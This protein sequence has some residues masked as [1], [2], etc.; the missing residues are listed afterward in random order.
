MSR[1]LSTNNVVSLTAQESDVVFLI[2]LTISH[3]DLSED[4][5]VVNNNENIT[6][7]GNEYIAFPF[8]IA[9]PSDADT[10]SANVQLRIDNVDRQIVQA[11]RKISSPASVS[12]EVVSSDDWDNV[13][14]SNLNMKLVHVSYD[15]LTVEGELVLDDILNEGFPADSYLPSNSSIV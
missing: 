10:L 13:E 9:L 15:S 3:P 6:S 8:D 5:R 12:I 14:L 4:I 2:L 11:V 1:T 7:R